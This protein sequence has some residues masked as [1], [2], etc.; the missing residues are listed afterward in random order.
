MQ[1]EWRDISSYEGLYAI[2]DSGRI[3][4]YPKRNRKKE[5][6][7]QPT[8]N[9]NGYLIVCLV[10]NKVRKNHYIHRLVAENFI[11]NLSYKKTVNHKDRDKKNNNVKNL[12][13]STYSEQI[14]HTFETGRKMPNKRVKTKRVISL[15]DKIIDLYKNGMS[16]SSIAK[17]LS[18]CP[19]TVNSVLIN[20]DISVKSS[21]E[22][23]SRKV[24]CTDQQ[25]NIVGNFNSI[26][27]A[28][29]WLI[30]NGY[31]K[32]CASSEI[33]KCCKGK[34]KTTRGFLWRYE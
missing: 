29:D 7:L 16:I 8:D 10:K 26:K 5:R 20:D 18:L 32:G 31:S 14:I 11:P 24:L 23:C 6:L 21:V 1:E 13:W 3:K 22:I 19:Q 9:G 34:S 4:S 12:E 25:G 2:S 28:S 30:V 33:S 27:E 15:S 17:Q